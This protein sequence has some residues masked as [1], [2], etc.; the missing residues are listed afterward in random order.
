MTY[1]DKTHSKKD[2]I[3]LLETFDIKVNPTLNKREIIQLIPKLIEDIKYEENCYNI[4]NKNELLLFLKNK[5]PII[6]LTAE[7]KKILMTKCKNIIY[8]CTNGY[9]LEDTLYTNRNQIMNDVIFVH[10]HGE[11]PSVR[12]CC[13]LYNMDNLKVNHVNPIIPE[14]IKKEL[15]NNRPNKCQTINKLIIKRGSFQLFFN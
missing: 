11:I 7:E 2:L 13:R 6:K 3:K 5:S 14:H 1:I 4:T 9:K 12:R 8:Y 10:T 15:E